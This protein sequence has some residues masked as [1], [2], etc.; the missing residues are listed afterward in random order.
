[1]IPA[2]KIVAYV[3]GELDDDARAEVEAA[4]ATD[5]TVADQ[6]A[7]HR[8][9][10]SDLFAA[11]APIAGEPVPD[12][13]LK[14][15]EA[16]S[17]TVLPFRPKL[18]RPRVTQIAAMA[19]CLVAGIALAMVFRPAGD[20]T[21]S[22]DGLIARGPL[23]RALSSQLAAD[24][25]LTFRDNGGTVCRTFTTKTSEGL[26]CR[27]DGEWHIEVAAR[28]APKTEFAQAG[29]PLILQAV[30]ARIS[31]DPLDATAERQ[32]RDAGW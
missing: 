5:P 10:R 2:E 27:T 3:D 28:A 11:F 32:A 1:M 22:S 29:S 16:P 8:G 13:L 26:A 9:L 31:G 7:A 20:F 14:A 17:A 4:A 30:D 12:G 25:G 15:T 21:S 6:I 23:D 19:A 18:S 24:E